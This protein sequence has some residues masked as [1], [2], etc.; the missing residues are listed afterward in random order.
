MTRKSASI[1]FRKIKMSKDAMKADQS[2]TG[3][4]ASAESMEAS[5]KSLEEDYQIRL[6]E[7]HAANQGTSTDLGGAFLMNLC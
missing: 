4:G 7:L 5:F 1:D 3:I 6:E 2:S